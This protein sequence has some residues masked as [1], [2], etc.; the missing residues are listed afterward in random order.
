M[1]ENIKIATA[2]ARPPFL[3]RAIRRLWR[4][5]V[6][7][8]YRNVMWLYFIKP[9]GAFQPFNDTSDDRYPGIFAFVAAE[10]GAA[11]KISILSY[12]CSTGD[13]VFSL[14]RYFPCANIKGLD[15][16]PANIAVCRRRLKNTPDANIVFA[17]ADSTGAEPSRDYDAIFCMAV[18]RHGSLG[19]PGVTRS[20]HLIR[21]E[22]FSRAVADFE[23]CL[24]PGG[25]L[26]IRHS[27]FRL[28]DAPAGRAFE[29]I[30]RLATGPGTPL[31]GPDN[32]RLADCDYP[33]TVFRKK[34]A[35]SRPSDP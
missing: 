18:L 33:D 1:I 20:D 31:F 17:T 4:L 5:A 6:D 2:I 29:T 19:L 24:K 10:L 35:V 12:G 7:R 30:L 16:N 21:F 32:Q 8:V 34:S 14:R 25:L 13:E 15:I 11:S 27:N 3:L 9:K 28:S 22:D 26:I 23:R